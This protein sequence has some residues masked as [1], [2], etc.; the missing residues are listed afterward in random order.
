[1]LLR[2]RYALRELLACEDL[3]QADDRLD[4]VDRE[5]LEHAGGAQRLALVFAEPVLD[6]ERLARG[7]DRFEHLLASRAWPADGAGRAGATNGSPR[8]LGVKRRR[9]LPG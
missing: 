2:V 1:V 7:C 3:E 9:G 8:G 5:A 6:G 4:R